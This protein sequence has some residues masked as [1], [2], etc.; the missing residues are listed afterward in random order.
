MMKIITVH[1]SVKDYN[2]NIDKSTLI[3]LHMV[4]KTLIKLSIR[5]GL[6]VES[7]S[8]KIQVSLRT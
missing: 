7:H 8:G 4:K 5:A 3:V 2:N 1:D 6:I